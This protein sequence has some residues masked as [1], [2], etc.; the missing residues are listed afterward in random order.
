M[1]VVIDVAS[2]R[3][4]IEGDGPELLKVL[5]AARALAPSVKQIQIITSMETTSNEGAEGS[6]KVESGSPPHSQVPKTLRS[7]ARSLSLNNAPERIAAIAYYINKIEGRHSF[8]PKE[9]DGWF[10]MC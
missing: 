6:G 2:G 10:T 4:A 7:F 9:L 5:E 8:S 1:K 3:L